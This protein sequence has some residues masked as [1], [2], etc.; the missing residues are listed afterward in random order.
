MDYTTKLVLI[1]QH[2]GNRLTIIG[3]FYIEC[4]FIEQ[5]ET[6]NLTNAKTDKS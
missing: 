4:Y 3:K 2:G 5:V 1:S 6:E